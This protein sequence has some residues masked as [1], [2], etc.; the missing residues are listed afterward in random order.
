M[1][2]SDFLLPTGGDSRSISLEQ[3]PT[4]ARIGALSIFWPSEKPRD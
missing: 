3:M 4:L 1:G 2:R